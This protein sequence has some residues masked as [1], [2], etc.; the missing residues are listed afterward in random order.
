MIKDLL[1]TAKQQ[2]DER[3]RRWGVLYVCGCQVCWGTFL[4]G[5][6]GAGGMAT[7]WAQAQGLRSSSAAHPPT[8]PTAFHPARRLATSAAGAVF[9]SVPHAGSRLADWGWYLR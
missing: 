3:L 2:K 9:Y 8:H 5:S 6:R 7:G 1:V 4:V